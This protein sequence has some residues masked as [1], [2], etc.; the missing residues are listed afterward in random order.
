MLP[1]STGVFVPSE[2]T[3]SSV[4]LV[5]LEEGRAL[6]LP[7]VREHDDPVGPR[8]VLGRPDDAVEGL[9]E[10]AKDGQRVRALDARVVGDLVVARERGVDRRPARVDVTDDRRHRQVALH[11]DH[12]RAQQRVHEPAMT[13]RPDVQAVLLRRRPQLLRDVG[14]HQH[15]GADERER[16]REV[17][18]VA[19]AG[20]LGVALLLA[21]RRDRERGVR[22][23]ARVHVRAAGAVRVQEALAGRQSRL[24]RQDVLRSRGRDRAAELLVP[25]AEGGDVLVRAE[26]KAGLRGP[27]LGRPVGLP[28]DEAMRALLHPAR[29][30]R[31]VPAAH[32]APEHVVAEAVDLEED[33]A[34]HVG[35]DRADL[36]HLPLDD[37]PVE[38]LVVVDR[39]HRR[40]DH[41]HDREPR[42]EQARPARR[43]RPRTRRPRP[44]RRARRTPRSARARRD[45]R[46]RP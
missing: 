19:G 41:G 25:P 8:R 18:E 34:G 9:V 42:R 16:V 20:P 22:R 39:Q 31:S 44:R 15:E 13:A 46:S 27:G 35:L 36:P 23:V 12:E 40:H 43:D 24:D 3:S 5:P 37:A 26:E 32:G 17:G 30:V 10:V 7:V 38:D 33:H 1:A 6:A 2:T 14:D 11:D 29:H 28:L 21:Q 4:V 45:R